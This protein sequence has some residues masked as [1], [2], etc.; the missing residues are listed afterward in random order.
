MKK[1]VILSLDLST[2]S[3]GW[4]V[5]EVESKEMLSSGVIRPKE[6]DF[7]ARAIMM[8]DFLQESVLNE[9]T[10]V[11]LALEDLSVIHNQQTLKKLAIVMGVILSMFQPKQ[12]HYCNVK[13]WRSYYQYASLKRDEAKEKAK[14]LVISYYPDKANIKLK[15]D[16]AEAILIG[17]YFVENIQPELV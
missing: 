3:T 2:S 13:K 6:K 16:E 9:Y 14:E 17:K 7:F 8:R 15:D 12:I 5:F 1:N 11:N 10:V 4:A